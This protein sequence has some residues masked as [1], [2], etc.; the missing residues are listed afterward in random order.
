M[1]QETTKAFNWIVGDKENVVG[2]V[3]GENISSRIA[4]LLSEVGSITYELTSVESDLYKI[5]I[6]DYGPKRNLLLARQ[7]LHGYCW[8]EYDRSKIS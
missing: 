6:E 8:S 7:F 2:Y 1:Q 4:R 3:V 5:T